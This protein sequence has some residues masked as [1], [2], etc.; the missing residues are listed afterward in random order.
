LGGELSPLDGMQQVVMREAP[1]Q[2]REM[3]E[4]AF[5]ALRLREGLSIADFEARFK[6]DIMR[7][8]GNAI[9]ETRALGLVEEVD[10]RL[11][12]RDEAVLLG[13]EAFV[14]FLEPATV[15]A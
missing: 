14:R 2:A 6:V 13:D 10:G 15:E 4:T 1:D 8:F 12:V 9:E 3:A 11:R 5:L 7:V